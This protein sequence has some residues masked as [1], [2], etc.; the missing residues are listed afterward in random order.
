MIDLEKAEIDHWRVLVIKV[1]DSDQALRDF[2]D[3]DNKIV[4]KFIEKISTCNL[5]IVLYVVALACCRMLQDVALW[6]GCASVA[7][8]C[9][10]AIEPCRCHASTLPPR[11]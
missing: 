6:P 7:P 4:P 11:S 8:L 10:P 1:Q 9:F 3:N 2:I 5:E